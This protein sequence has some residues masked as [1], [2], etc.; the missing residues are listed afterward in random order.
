MI[1]FS[2]NIK[3]FL[4]EAFPAESSGLKGLFP[5][6]QRLVNENINIE[7]GKI[8]NYGFEMVLFL[9]CLSFFKTL[10]MMIPNQK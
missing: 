3:D 5:P 2:W 6:P 7:G 4:Q 9:F 1:I 10:L 8:E